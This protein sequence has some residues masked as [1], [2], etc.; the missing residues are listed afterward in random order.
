[1]YDFA[2]DLRRYVEVC[3]PTLSDIDHSK[4]AALTYW[5]GLN[6]TETIRHL[7]V[8]YNS[9][10]LPGRTLIISQICADLVRI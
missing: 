8:A 9:T 2:S 5:Y 6:Q 4:V 10:T 3:L 1:M 7:P